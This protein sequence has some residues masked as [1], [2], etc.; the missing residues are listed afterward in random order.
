[1]A[2]PT[3][4][5]KV[6]CMECGKTWKVSPNSDGPYCPKCNSADIEVAE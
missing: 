3:T 1:M 4:R 5:V 2:K 6:K